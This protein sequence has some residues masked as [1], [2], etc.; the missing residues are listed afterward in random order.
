MNWTRKDLA[1]DLNGFKYPLTH[2]FYFQSALQADAKTPAKEAK[3]GE[4]K[5]PGTDKKRGQKRNAKKAFDDE[6][7][8]VTENE[9]EIGETVV[10]LDW[11]DSDLSMRID[12]E[13]HMSGEPFNR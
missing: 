4:A 3:E 1:F 8:V 7:F 12:K 6:P 10:C 13:E 11:Y 5:T 2:C 9:P